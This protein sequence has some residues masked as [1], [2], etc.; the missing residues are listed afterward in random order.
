MTSAV[1]TCPRCGIRRQVHESRTGELCRDCWLVERNAP[2]AAVMRGPAALR[3]NEL[4]AMRARIDAEIAALQRAAQRRTGSHRPAICGTE[5][6]YSKHRRE[7]EETCEACK[8]ARREGER[9]R[10]ARRIM[11]RPIISEIATN[12]AA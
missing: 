8:K 2:Q 11:R 7:G 5:S 3:L 4:L 6:G 9:R 10:A 12:G 1:R